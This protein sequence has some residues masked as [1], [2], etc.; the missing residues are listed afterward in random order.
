MKRSRTLAL[1][2]LAAGLGGCVAA[3][4]PTL[5]AAP[6]QAA[7]TLSATGAYDPAALLAAAADDAVQRVIPTLGEPGTV[8]GVL[9]AFQAL[10]DA[11][12]AGDA[13]GKAAAA[14]QAR[15]ALDALAQAAPDTDA[16]ELAALRLV[17]DTAG[18]AEAL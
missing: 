7:A 9:G 1:P 16:V 18:A 11:T 12:R 15:A 5:P 17:L 2:L 8:A 14:A 13:A 3:D 4:A 6:P 10:G